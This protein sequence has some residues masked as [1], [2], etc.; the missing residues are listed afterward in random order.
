MLSA[1]SQDLFL[2]H[3]GNMPAAEKVA[4]VRVGQSKSDVAGILG[5][6]SSTTAFGDENW[7][8]MSSTVKK[9]AFF[10]P[11]E[12]ERDLLEIKFDSNGKVTEIVKL[13]QSDGRNL[14]IDSEQTATVGHKIGFFQKYFGGVGTYMP[15]APT[16]EN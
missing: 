2:V 9:M 4:L 15:V 11:E 3:N 14:T 7:I 5:S 6:P 1:C 8:Y 13:D 12:L 16:K 10:Q